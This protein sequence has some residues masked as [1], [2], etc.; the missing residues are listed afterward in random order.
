MQP[1][2]VF[3]FTVEPRRFVD[4]I[5]SVPNETSSDWHRALHAMPRALTSSVPAMIAAS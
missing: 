4:F 2:A 1:G 5:E 3:S